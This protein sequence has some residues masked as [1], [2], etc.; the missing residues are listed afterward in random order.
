MGAAV[1]GLLGGRQGHVKVV[2]ESVAIRP[3]DE[4]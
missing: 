4:L 3:A 2:I 1:K